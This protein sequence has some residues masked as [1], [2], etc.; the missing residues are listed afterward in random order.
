MFRKNIIPVTKKIVKKKVVHKNTKNNSPNLWVSATSIKNYI[1]NDPL[2]DWLYLYHRRNNQNNSNNREENILFKM[3][4]KFEDHVMAHLKNK[5]PQDIKKIVCNFKDLN[6]EMVNMT[7]E[8]MIQGIPIIE[9]A[10]LY[11]FQNMTFGVADLLVRVDWINKL[12]NMPLISENEYFRCRSLNGNYHYRVIDIK[13]STMHLCRDKKTIRNMGMFP[14]YKGQLAIYNAALGSLQGYVPSTAYILAKS[15]KTDYEQGHN[16]FDLLG[17]IDF[18]N[19]DKEYLYKTEDAIKWV[20]NVRLNGMDWDS[21]NPHIPELYPNMSNTHDGPYKKIKMEL[22]EK[23]KELTQIYMVGYKNRRIAHAKKIYSWDHPQCSSKNLGI[24]GKKISL[25]VDQII[26][27]NRSQNEIIKPDIIKNNTGSWQ[28]KTNNDF[29]IDI[30]TI[31]QNLYDQEINLSNGYSGQL[32]FLVGI[33]FEEDGQWCYKYFISEQIDEYGEFSVI[34]QM[35]DFIKSKTSYPKFFHW[36]HLE[37]STLDKIN[38]KHN[39]LWGD[40]I[41]NI[42]WVD[43]CRVFIE[44]PIVIKGAKKFNLKE[45]ANAMESHRMINSKWDNNGPDNGFSAMI[46]AI[47]NYKNKLQDMSSIIRYNE[48]DCKVVWEIVSYLRNSHTSKV[49][50]IQ[51]KSIITKN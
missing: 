30:E 49:K 13:W 47:N 17:Q 26:K 36:S 4:N 23:L 34:G 10:A 50:P 18:E 9:Q 21:H 33:G 14:A 15:W 35:F 5:F 22:A 45:I 29:Y 12:L 20:R 19:F 27:I 41:E 32:I 48:I 6:P 16:C 39:N 28:T 8:C 25:I 37:K 11:N 46:S 44:E 7:K 42:T 40:I 3:G 24:N 1:L 51:I 31:A 2:L 38:Q 43:M